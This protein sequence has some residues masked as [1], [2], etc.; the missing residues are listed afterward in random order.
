ML[1]RW[2][3]ANNRSEFPP[4]PA[5]L[6]YV[7]GQRGLQRGNKE[8]KGCS[9]SS[10]SRGRQTAI[11]LLNAKTVAGLQRGSG[12]V[13]HDKIAVRRVLEAVVGRHQGLPSVLEGENV[14]KT[15]WCGTCRP[16]EAVL[17]A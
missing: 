4:R 16:I 5:M 15:G 14:V 2:R 10:S 8:K 17:A 3:S 12:P 13:G 7:L 1:L 6:F 11:R 9:M